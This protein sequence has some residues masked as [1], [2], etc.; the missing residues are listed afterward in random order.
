MPIF[1]KTYGSKDAADLAFQR[2]RIFFIWCAE[3]WG[4]EQGYVCALLSSGVS[5]RAAFASH[6][7]SH[8]SLRS[9]EWIVSHYLF[10][11]NPHAAAA[12]ELKSKL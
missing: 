3:T 11:K 7:L 6:L 2:W 5:F 12:A 8:V 1:E 4:F 10:K 9:R